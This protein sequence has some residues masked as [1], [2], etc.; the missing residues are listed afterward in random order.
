ME[1]KT[2]LKGNVLLLAHVGDMDACASFV[3]FEELAKKISKAKLEFAVS[4]LLNKDGEKILNL[5]G[6]KAKKLSDI[7][8]ENFQKLVLVDTSEDLAKD[9][10]AKFKDNLVLDHHVQTK[11]FSYAVSTTEIIY[12]L[13]KKN[14]VKISEK[15]AKAITYGIISDTR[16]LRFAKN[17]TFAILSDI[18]TENKLD[19]QKLLEEI[20]EETH[21]DE[22]LAWL[23][24]AQRLQVHELGNKIL[25]VST[26]GGFESSAASKLMALGADVV[27]VISHKTKETRIVGR[28]K[29]PY[30]LAEVFQ[31]IAS[32]VSGTGGGHPGAAAM[33]FPPEKEKE[34]LSKVIK[35]IKA[36]SL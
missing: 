19:Y 11:E 16:G 32:E 3:A 20:A 36:Q 31:K 15:A 7:K 5:F 14:K 13:F 34:A 2:W 9:V 21:P 30:N 26:V 17:K 6:L 18:L 23:K 22:K 12:D 29:S 35:L 24:A 33:N 28:A 10:I 1:L 25:I 27:L 8:I 4:G